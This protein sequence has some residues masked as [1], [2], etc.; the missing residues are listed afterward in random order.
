MSPYLAYFLGVLTI[1]IIIL[2]F[3]LIARANPAVRQSYLNL[4]CQVT[5]ETESE[6]NTGTSV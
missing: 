2:I 5:P 1:V 3:Y 4:F 6:N